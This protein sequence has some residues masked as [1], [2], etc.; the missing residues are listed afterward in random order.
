[1]RLHSG[2][3]VLFT[4]F[5][6][7]PVA[8]AANKDPVTALSVIGAIPGPDGGWDFASVDADARRLYVA[9]GDAVMAVDLDSGKVEAKK[10]MEGKGLHAVLPLPDGR[11]LTTNGGNNTATL[12]DAAT[13]NIIAA[14]PTGQ[15]PDAAIFDQPSGL[16]L[17]M[18]ARSGDVTLIDPKTA[19]SPGRIEVG[20]ALE[21]AAV[22]GH[23]KAFVN[24]EDK[25]EIA[26][27]D[28]AGRKVLTRYA[29][30]GCDG[31]TG[32]AI[33][34]DNGLLIAA[35]ANGKAIAL[36]AKDGGIAATLPIG[37][38]PD[39]VIFDPNRKVF[40]IPCGEGSLAVIAA[41][42]GAAP[43]IVAT[44]QTQN[45][46][47]TGALDVKTGRLYLPTADFRDP[48]PGEKRRTVVP[49]TFRILVVGS[50]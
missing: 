13:G 5:Q 22:D 31:P 11:I 3:L 32:L 1:M 16:A 10:S 18:N 23:G 37:L 30:P 48:A 49:G 41:K 43:A 45:G 29:L 20:G 12:F 38:R 6:L 27:L 15:K 35:C 8:H 24:I 2:L 39:G 4:V 7:Q 42:Y 28:I 19:T 17:V 34:P 36:S 47:R 26:V 40:F 14:I 46:A 33:G 44:I 9:H 21:Y 50:K 25:N